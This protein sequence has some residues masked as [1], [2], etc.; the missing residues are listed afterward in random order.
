[1]CFDQCV[2]QWNVSWTKKIERAVVNFV[3]GLCQA[4]LKPEATTTQ[5]LAL[6]T[7]NNCRPQGW[8]SHLLW[9]KIPIRI[10]LS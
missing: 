4:K 1:M 6:V 3:Q 7:Q 8:T 5:L 2:F 9:K 10:E